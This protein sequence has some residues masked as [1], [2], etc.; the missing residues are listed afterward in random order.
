MYLEG[1]IYLSRWCFS[2][3]RLS[4]SPKALFGSREYAFG[5]S[6]IDFWTVSQRDNGYMVNFD[7]VFVS[8]NYSSVASI[9]CVKL[10]KASDMNE[11]ST[12]VAKVDRI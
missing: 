3:L 6:C 4:V 10:V 7:Y 1:Q 9:R 8:L 2:Y 5:V 11:L 12:K